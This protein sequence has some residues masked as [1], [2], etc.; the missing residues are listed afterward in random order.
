[1]LRFLADRGAVP[2]YVFEYEPG[3]MVKIVGS[4]SDDELRAAVS[5]VGPVDQN[6]IESIP[7]SD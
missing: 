7:I 3:L 5:S 2:G 6:Q 1:V 4:V